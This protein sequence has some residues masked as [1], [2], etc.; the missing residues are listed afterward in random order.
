M[1]QIEL[2]G[3]RKSYGKERAVQNLDLTVNPGDFLT[4]L[5]PSGCGKT[6]TLRAIAGLE[7]PDEGEIRFGEKVVFSRR[8]GVIIPPE[9]R[10]VGFIFQSYALW[11]HMTVE[12]NITLALKEK[13]LSRNEVESR[14]LKSLEMVQ[15]EAY[16]KRYPSELS[17]GQQQ[18]VAV[19]RLIALQSEILLM[20]EPLSN[21]DA[22]LRTE[23]R[24][25]LKRLHR[26]LEATTVYVTHDQTEA[27]TLSDIVV[28]M[29]KGLMIQRGT[30]YDIYHHPQSLFVAEFIGD[31]RINFFKGMLVS[32]GER[33][34]LDCKEFLLPFNKELPSNSGVVIAAVRPE[35]I[36]LSYEDRKDWIKVELKSIQPTGANT[37]L[38]V[39]IGKVEITLMQPGFIRMNLEESLWIKFDS[40]SL[41]FFSEET[42]RNLNI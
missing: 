24:A 28:V 5:G 13:R 10:N 31:P 41:N 33:R 37:I 35:S 42:E 20:D 23:M 38:Q 29:N 16:R 14:L 22:K 19:S 15:M 1:E 32:K 12:Q 25:E 11:P 18:R 26:E 3:I 27:L 36:L 40:E 6:T 21:L 34:Y 39:Q 17:G 8:Q 30:P 2:T 7:E 4:I 9:S